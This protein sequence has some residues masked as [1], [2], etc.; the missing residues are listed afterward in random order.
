[1]CMVFVLCVFGET[2]L[3]FSVDVQTHYH[4]LIK[5][6]G[7]QVSSNYIIFRTN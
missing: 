4:F 1:M 6:N 3:K 5:G 7:R 2:G